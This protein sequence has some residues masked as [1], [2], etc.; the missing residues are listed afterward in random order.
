VKSSVFF[1]RYTQFAEAA[2]ERW[3]PA[4]KLPNQMHRRGFTAKRTKS[5]VIYLGIELENPQEDW[6]AV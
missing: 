6:R 3:M 2:G 4:K 1:Q 5:G